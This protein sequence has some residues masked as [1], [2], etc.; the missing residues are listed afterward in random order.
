VK[1]DTLSTGLSSHV[2]SWEE[3]AASAVI[4]FQKLLALSTL[5]HYSYIGND[6]ND[7][8]S[9][10][11]HLSSIS[12]EVIWFDTSDQEGENLTRGIKR[13]DNL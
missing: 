8:S 2:S 10:S 13:I 6:I 5:N 9:L 11:G 4:P 7:L 3:T 12:S 1:F